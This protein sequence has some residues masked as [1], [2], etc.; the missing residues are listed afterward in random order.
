MAAECS[1]GTGA[2]Q[3]GQSC[4]LPAILI[5]IHILILILLLLGV[6]PSPALQLQEAQQEDAP[7]PCRAFPS[8]FD[9]DGS[10]GTYRGFG[11]V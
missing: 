4:I 1:T 7:P 6:K 2:V 3:E 9:A 8:G 10:V 5:P 11:C